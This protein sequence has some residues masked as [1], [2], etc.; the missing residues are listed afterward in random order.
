MVL[1][2]AFSAWLYTLRMA[3]GC[4]K[5]FTVHV[6][7]SVM[8]WVVREILDL[9]FHE[10]ALRF[11][12]M[13]PLYL[14]FMGCLQMTCAEVLSEGNGG[15]GWRG[16][17]GGPWRQCASRRVTRRLPPCVTRNLDPGQ[18]GACFMSTHKHSE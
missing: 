4:R 1:A 17:I 15:E 18:Q 3:V 13:E 11:S 10:D 9:R 14:D 5:E 12:S 16:R 7:V 6:T 2:V 8:W